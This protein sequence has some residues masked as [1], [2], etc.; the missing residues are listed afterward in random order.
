[1][2]TSQIAALAGNLRSVWTAQSTDARLE[3]RI[4]RTLIHEVV[5]DLDDVTA[6]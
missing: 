1:M 4:V 2:F 5:A 6:R 3:T